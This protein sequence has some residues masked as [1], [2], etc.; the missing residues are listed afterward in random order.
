[1]RSVG[2][3]ASLWHPITTT[4]LVVHFFELPEPALRVKRL[5]VAQISDLHISSRLPKAYFEA[6]LDSVVAQDPDLIFVT[7]DNVS[8][9]DSL[10]LLSEVLTGRLHAR[11]GVFAVLGNHDFETAPEAVRQALSAAGITRVSSDCVRLPQSIGR[12]VVCGTE[13]PWGPKLETPLAA[14]DLSLILSH[15]PDNIYDLAA[16]GASVVFSGHTHGGQLRVPGFGAL[17]V[18]SSYGRRFD[19]GHF[20]VGGAD[21]FVSTGLGAYHPPLRIYCQPDVIVVDLVNDQGV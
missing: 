20:R 11:F 5:R 18:P 16:Q 21:L 14:H 2:A 12:V 13:A 8:H 7:G 9:V 19:E 15:T 10:P 4:D 17:V 3:A 6:A 1:V